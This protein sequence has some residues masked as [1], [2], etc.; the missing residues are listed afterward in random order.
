MLY[1]ADYR[2]MARSALRGKWGPAVLTTFIAALLGGVAKSGSSSGVRFHV[3]LSERNFSLQ[4]EAG[5]MIF[6][7][8]LPYYFLT[9]LQLAAGLVIVYGILTFIIGA[10]VEIGLNTFYIRLAYGDSPSVGSL[11]EKFGYIG[12]ALGLRLVISLF[13]FL[14]SLLFIIP[15]IIAAYRYSMA[16][17][18]LAENPDMGIMDAIH[19]SGEIMNGNK[20]R[21]FCLQF[22]FIGWNILAS[23][24][25]GVGFLFVTPYY[26]AAK[27]GFYLDITR[28]SGYDNRDGQYLYTDNWHGD[29]YSGQ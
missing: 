21:L 18:L 11:F 3:D 15:G 28:Q 14:W 23:F 5:H 7:Y 20:W 26:L 22:S 2:Q 16:T 6:N 8:T 12:K 4:N 24:T 27:T 9:F 1:A 25:M 29:D 10:A 17:Y 13:T 19:E